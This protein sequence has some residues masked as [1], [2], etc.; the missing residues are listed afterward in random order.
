MNQAADQLVK[1]DDGISLSKGHLVVDSMGHNS[2]LQRLISEAVSVHPLSGCTHGGALLVSRKSKRLSFEITTSP[3]PSALI[4]NQRQLAALV[5][6]ADPASAPL[7]R[8]STLRALYGLSPL[9]CRLADLLA[10][11]QDVAAAAEPLRLTVD[12]TRSHLKSIFRKTGTNRQTD[13]IRRIL[14]IPGTF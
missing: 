13:L 5:F 9:E 2:E 11:G 4:H 1:S 10:S 14:G 6:I 12:A 7:S 8:S 3:V